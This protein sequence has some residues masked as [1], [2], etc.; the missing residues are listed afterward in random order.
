MLTFLTYKEIFQIYKKKK[1]KKTNTDRKLGG[2]RPKQEIDR[3][4]D[5]E[6]RLS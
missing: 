6:N 5:T 2:E 4:I 3:R 1:K